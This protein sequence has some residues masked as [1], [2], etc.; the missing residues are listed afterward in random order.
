MNAYALL[1]A[2][3]LLLASVAW[4]APVLAVPRLD[5]E[6]VGWP[7]EAIR[8]A[9]PVDGHYMLI[10]H[11]PIAGDRLYAS[12]ELEAGLTATTMLPPRRH[13]RPGTSYHIQVMEDAYRSMILLETVRYQRQQV[14]FLGMVRS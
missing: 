8:Y 13:E 2:F 6:Y 5:S 7:V 12:W 11:D 14:L 3:L 10:A 1:L 9:T 4:P